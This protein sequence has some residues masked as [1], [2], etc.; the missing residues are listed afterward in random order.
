M[1]RGVA[2][3]VWELSY[4]MILLEVGTKENMSD[5]VDLILTHVEDVDQLLQLT[6]EMNARQEYE[7]IIRIGERCFSIAAANLEKDLEDQS[8]ILKEQF[9]ALLKKLPAVI[10][11]IAP[12]IYMDLL[13]TNCVAPSPSTNWVQPDF[14]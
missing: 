6:Q 14:R 5:V 8:K 1:P 10:S 13:L 12:H 3:W 9:D 7:L 2:R 4:E 11:Y